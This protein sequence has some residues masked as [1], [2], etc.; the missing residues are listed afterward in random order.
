M[1][2]LNLPMESLPPYSPPQ[3]RPHLDVILNPANRSGVQRRVTQVMANT[4]TSTATAVSTSIT[5]TFAPTSNP[6]ACESSRA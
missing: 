1:P 2:I 3:V 6:M 4:A 5:T